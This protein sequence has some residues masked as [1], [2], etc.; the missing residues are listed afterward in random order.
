MIICKH[1]RFGFDLWALFLFLAVMI[2]TII[3][4]FVPAPND[5]LRTESSTPTIDTI[6]S[7]LQFIAITCLCVVINK[8]AGKIWLSPLVILSASSVLIYY[9]SWVIY[10]CGISAPWIILLMTIPP[11]LAL[12]LYSVD[13]KN[14]PATILAIGFAISHLVFAIVNFIR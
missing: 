3:W 1:Y 11:C 10:Y 9:A 5:I 7:I 2:P 13:R 12:I 4:A 6:A 8:D 14:L